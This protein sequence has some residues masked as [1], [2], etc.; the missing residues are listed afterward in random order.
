LPQHHI[1]HRADPALQSAPAHSAELLVAVTVVPAEM[2]RLQ[3]KAAEAEPPDIRAP[4]VLVEMALALT[5][6][7]VQVA[8]AVAAEQPPVLAE[9]VM[10]R[11][12]EVSGFSDKEPMDPVE[13]QDLEQRIPRAPVVR[14]DPLEMPEMQ[15]QRYL[16]MVEI[17]VAVAEVDQ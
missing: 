11:A 16:D 9:V 1:M 4:V 17:M 12:A 7:Q 10:H 5:A 8:V 15:D 13:L 6:V 14:A 2:D 3:G